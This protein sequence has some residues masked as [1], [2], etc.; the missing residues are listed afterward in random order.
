[1]KNDSH[2]YPFPTMEDKF[3]DTNKDGKLTGSET[4]FRDA[5]LLEMA[6]KIDAETGNQ[7]PA[8]SSGS[9]LGVTPFQI[10]MLILFVL[11]LLDMLSK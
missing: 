9:G 11:F 2:I 8:H 1:M 3:F 4:I 7:E 10:I 5:H 6:D